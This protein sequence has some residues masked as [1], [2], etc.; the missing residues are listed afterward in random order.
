M[1]LVGMCCFDGAEEKKQA[2]EGS[3]SGQGDQISAAQ[4]NPASDKG[5]NPLVPGKV[6]YVYRSAKPARQSHHMLL[7]VGTQVDPPWL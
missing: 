6:V 7:L 5:Y 2:I 3:P 1:H 4:T